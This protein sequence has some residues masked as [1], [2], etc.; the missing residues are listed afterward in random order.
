MEQYNIDQKIQEFIAK[1]EAKN[2]N[3]P[4]FIQDVKE[5]AVTVIP[6]ARNTIPI[7]GKIK[8]VLNKAPRCAVPASLN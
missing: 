8:P 2:P 1:I 5:V 6:L 3:E 4:E 7:T